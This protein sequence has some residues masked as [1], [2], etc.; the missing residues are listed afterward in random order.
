[1]KEVAIKANNW[2]LWNIRSVA[3]IASKQDIWAIEKA[4]AL[5]IPY[6]VLKN[7]KD[8]YE[9]LSILNKYRA[10]I[11]SL[12][13]WL[14]QI[15]EEVIS[16]FSS[17]GGIL[18][19]QHPGPVRADWL[20]F[21]W[22]G[23]LWMY[24]SR[25]TTARVLYLLATSA[26]WAWVFTESTV[27]EVIPEVDRGLPVW[28]IRMSFP[29]E[30]DDFRIESGIIWSKQLDVIEYDNPLDPT[31]KEIK[32]IIEKI[33]ALLLPIEHKNV[34]NVFERLWNWELDLEKEDIYLDSLVPEINKWILI[35]AKERAVQ[36]FPKG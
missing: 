21:W 17:Q 6:E 34:A 2:D 9:I 16:K 8:P 27:H 31:I 11:A 35:E 10:N 23:K 36:L 5:G 15:P 3:V 30:L 4:T 20:D 25:V 26:Q 13:G 14:P 19:N 12:N 32:K 1:M 28:I 33:Q 22:A 18:L 7:S 29:A 24:W